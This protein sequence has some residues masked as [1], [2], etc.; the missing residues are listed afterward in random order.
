MENYTRFD[1]DHK[2]LLQLAANWVAKNEITRFTCALCV[3]PWNLHNNYTRSHLHW[4]IAQLAGWREKNQLIAKYSFTILLAPS[5]CTPEPSA[6]WSVWWAGLPC[7]FDLLFNICDDSFRVILM[8]CSC[9][10]NCV[11]SAVYAFAVFLLVWPRV[12]LHT[13]IWGHIWRLKIIVCS[14]H[15][16]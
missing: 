11:C 7:N 10:N 8:V 3:I 1:F 12:L 13:L 5:R 14:L 9:I 6:K 15:R 16:E 2:T 4:H